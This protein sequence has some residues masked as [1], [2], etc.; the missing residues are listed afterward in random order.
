M[1][2]EVKRLPP[3]E[4]YNYSKI[5][6][7]ALVYEH[8]EGDD[9]QTSLMVGMAANHDIHI[10]AD[11]PGVAAVSHTLTLADFDALVE[12]VHQFHAEVPQDA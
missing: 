12:A 11:R 7:Y 3:D 6:P 1:A 5:K 10:R 8:H 9:E 4:G 2:D